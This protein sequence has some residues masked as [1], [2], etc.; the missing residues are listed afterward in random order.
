MLLHN[1]CRESKV[2]SPKE[3]GIKNQAAK[4]G[5]SRAINRAESKAIETQESSLM[6]S[7]RTTANPKTPIRQNKFQPNSK[8]PALL[9]LIFPLR[10]APTALSSTSQP[11]PA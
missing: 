4:M 10:V 7:S 5:K 9:S 3:I 1:R 11:I 2:T 6:T 8:R